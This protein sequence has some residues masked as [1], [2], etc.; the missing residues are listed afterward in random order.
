M[1]DGGALLAT[2]PAWGFSA[3][4]LVARIG[5][6]CM[7]LPGVGEAEVPAM[8]R[9]G[10]TLVLT[11]LLLPVVFALPPPVPESPVMLMGMVAAECVTGLWLGWL[12]RLPVL[13][14]PMGGQI[15]ATM[16][17]LSSVLQPD[18]A[19][20]AQSSALARM[21]SLIAPVLVL[22]TGLYR[23]PLAA[24]AG[25]YRLVEAGALLPSADATSG[26]VAAVG[27]AFALALQL[28]A[29][30]VLASV[31]WQAGLG[32]AARLVPSLQVFTA[33]M[34]GQILGGL[35]LLA[36]LAGSVLGAWRDAMGA[37]L[38]ALPGL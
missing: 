5:C 3:M 13:A 14:L 1:V 27:A 12:A 25:S 19:L 32:L 35:A 8:L 36:L 24:L 33:A 28:S 11:G 23:L 29:P 6:A 15:I 18:P 16:T 22:G 26:V 17:G 2:L 4:L 34:P 21:F 38:A 31:V 37:A 20:G 9:I 10:M 30:F 7:L